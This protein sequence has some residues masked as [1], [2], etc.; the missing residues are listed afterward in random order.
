M[1]Y[2]NYSNALLG[3]I[4]KIVNDDL[5][6]AKDILQ[7][8]MVKIWNNVNGYE[9]SKGTLFTWMLNICR[10]LAIDRTR[11]RDF[12]NQSKNISFNDQGT[13]VDE[14][15]DEFKADTIGVKKLLNVLSP[16]Q[17]QVVDAVYMLGYTHSEAAARLKLPVGT[18]KTRLRSAIMELRK[19]IKSN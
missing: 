13:E 10:N 17:K 16:E 7:E 8:A 19:Y 11:S 4:R 9:S 18:V 5:E 2:S 1:L 14:M 6:L 12:K 3:I 15:T